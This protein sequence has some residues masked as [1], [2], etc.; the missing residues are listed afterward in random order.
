MVRIV[1][2]SLWSGLTGHFS[3]CVKVKNITA[4][5]PTKKWKADVRHP[6]QLFK[7]N[8]LPFCSFLHFFCLFLSLWLS[9]IDRQLCAGACKCSCTGAFRFI[10]IQT[11]WF[12]PR[13][14]C[15]HMMLLLLLILFSYFTFSCCS[16]FCF[17][18]SFFRFLDELTAFWQESILE[19]F[20]LRVRIFCGI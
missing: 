14:Q 13:L 4:R 3:L 12:L 9:F 15:T 2:I 17:L 5:Y 16:D 1:P 10:Y 7:W 6:H 20:C 11:S 18:L 8:A 19:S